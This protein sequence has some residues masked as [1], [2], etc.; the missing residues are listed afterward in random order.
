MSFSTSYLNIDNAILFG[1]Q[2]FLEELT[3]ETKPYSHKL[4]SV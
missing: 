3:K 1:G 4:G 2:M